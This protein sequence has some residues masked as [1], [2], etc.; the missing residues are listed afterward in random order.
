MSALLQLR[1]YDAC[2]LWLE[3]IKAKSTL[4]AYTIHISLF[5]KFHNV[6]PDQLIQLNN[7][8]GQLKTMI[9]NYII[10]LKR[11]AK[12]S[13]GKPRKGELSVNSVKLYLS[14]VK[15]FL[16]F[17]EITLPWKKI[18]K[19][20]PDDVTNS[21]RSYTKEEII[22]LLSVA[23]PR[24][25]CIILLMASSGIRVGAIQTLKV[26]SVQRLDNGIG[27]VRVYPESKDSVYAAL[28]TPEFLTSLDKYLK[29]RKSQGEKITAESWLIR[30]K[31]ATFS[32]KTNKPK[33]PSVESINKQMRFL[34]RKAGLS[35]EELQPDHSLR[36]FFNTALMNSDVAYTFKELLMGHSVKL[37]NIYYDKENEKSQQKILLEYM[38]AIDAL[39]VNEE[40]RLRNQIAEF[41]EKL[42]DVP[43]VEQLESHLANRIL[44]QEAIK[45]QL[46]KL[47]T[48]KEKETQT[49]QQKHE[50]DMK[51]MRE[52]MEN[53]FQ[54]ILTRI[55]VRKLG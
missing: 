45:K 1:E 37:D 44:E 27:I 23:D 31:F 35:F 19:F 49:T 4:Y 16:E 15:S 3:S 13:A 42:K 54:Q 25:R 10:H 24:D 18:A 17:N 41:E 51:A 52:E 9:L 53:R 34:L 39:T 33:P 29:Y 6:N 28:V 2:T 36:K 43:R 30:D 47:R 22:K 11:I 14:G 55:E 5:C 12:K 50:Q 38:K 32:K 26:K 7:P 46:E 21:Y 20:Y 48:D 8:A 40:Y